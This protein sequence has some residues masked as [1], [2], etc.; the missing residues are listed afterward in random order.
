MKKGKNSPE[1]LLIEIVKLDSIQFLGVC[2]ILGIELFDKDDSNIDSKKI[3]AKP[4][5]FDDIWLD[6]CDMISEMN[7]TRRRNLG[8]LIYAATK[9][10]KEGDE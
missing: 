2:K 5:N 10:E 4:R 1:N 7:R 6:L 8:K 3:D 9:K